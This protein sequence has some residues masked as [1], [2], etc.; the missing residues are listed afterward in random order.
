MSFY[1]IAVAAIFLVLPLMAQT[2]P[3][4]AGQAAA[5]PAQA[6][7]KPVDQADQ[8]PT[9]P[10][11]PGG[12]THVMGFEEAKRNAKGKLTIVE[13]K[14]KFDKSAIDISSI[15]DVFTGSESRQVGGTP[16]TLVK[17]AAPFG[18]GRALSLFAHQQVDNIT[19]EYTDSN[20]G[21]HDAIFLMPKGNAEHFKKDLITQGAHASTPALE[22]RAKTEAGKE[23]K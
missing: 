7:T 23:K 12:A 20:G 13:G 10:P 3:A 4:S 2:A 11:T 14:L 5:P 17:L 21:L 1:R 15:S 19:I 22:E 6:A 9:P 8:P 16:L 18:T